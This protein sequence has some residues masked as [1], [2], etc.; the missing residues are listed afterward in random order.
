MTDAPPSQSQTAAGAPVVASRDARAGYRRVIE[1]IPSRLRIPVLIGSLALMCL[2]LYGVWSSGNATLQVV[3]RHNFRSADLAVRVDGNLAFS[4]HL[5]GGSRKRF[6]LFEQV[7]GNFSRS[8]ALPSGGH[9][10]EV[11]LKSAEDGF[12]QTKSSR[13]QLPSGEVTALQVST[14]RNS[15]SLS[16]QGPDVSSAGWSRFGDGLQSIAVSLIGAAASA[17]IGFFV[18]DYLRSKKTD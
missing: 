7:E 15:L 5:S 14:S 6:G 1:R 17:G 4:E 10:V 18:Q 2:G 13:I 12:N 16:Y 9:L 11:Q 8:L 3:C